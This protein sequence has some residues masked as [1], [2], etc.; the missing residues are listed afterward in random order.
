MSI[1]IRCVNQ[2][3]RIDTY[4]SVQWIQAYINMLYRT[5]PS[6]TL[7]YMLEITIQKNVL[8][9]ELFQEIITDNPTFMGLSFFVDHVNGYWS[10][11][12]SREILKTLFIIKM[13]LKKISDID[14]D[15]DEY[16]IED[17]LAYSSIVGEKIIFC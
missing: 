1:I 3:I 9:Y 7:I 6:S 16:Y 14:F 4:S 10:S 5:D 17:I 8:N 12:T 11:N 13:D 2:S 15:D